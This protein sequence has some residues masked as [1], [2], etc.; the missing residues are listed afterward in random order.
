MCVCVCVRAGITGLEEGV[1]V[2]VCVCA[3][4]CVKRAGITGLEEGVCA[5]S[6]VSVDLLGNA[7]KGH[8]FI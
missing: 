4:A 8:F 7:I 6:S 5:F 1:C 3:C 2:C